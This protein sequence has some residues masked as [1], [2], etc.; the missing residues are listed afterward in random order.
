MVKGRLGS[1][2]VSSATDCETKNKE[3]FFFCLFSLI[4]YLCSRVFALP[5]M[6]R[7]EDTRKESEGL[8]TSGSLV[9]KIQF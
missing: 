3:Q 5:H 2:S 6:W 4:I 9:I 7:A 8:M 1:V